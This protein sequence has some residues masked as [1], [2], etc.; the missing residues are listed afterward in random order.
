MLP[1][2]LATTDRKLEQKL[3]QLEVLRQD[4]SAVIDGFAAG[5][6]GPAR[7]TRRRLGRI[8]KELDEGLRRLDHR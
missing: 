2:T 6:S 7:E 8:G 4:L 3:E 5:S 1:A